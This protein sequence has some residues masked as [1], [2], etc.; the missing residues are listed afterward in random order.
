[1]N[2]KAERGNN[3]STNEKTFGAGEVIIKEGDSGNT[4]FQL[5]EGNVGVYQ[6]YGQ[7]DEVVVAT[8]GP[9]QYFGEMAVIENYPRSSTVVAE[10]EVKVI[11]IAAEE[12]NDYISQ[13]PDKI[14]TI[15]K[16][17]GS[18]IKTMTDDYNDAKAMLDDIRKVNSSKNYDSFFNNMMQKSIFLSAKNFRMEQPSAESL[19]EAAEEVSKQKT[20]DVITYKYGTIIFKQGEA[21][22]CM[23][24]VHSGSVNLYS[25]YGAVNELKLAEVTP[26]ACFG[27][28]GMISGEARSAT[29]VTEEND[30]SVE[31]IYP[32]DL[33]KLFKES[34]AKI[35]MILK[36]L[37]YRLRRITYDYFKACQEIYVATG[38]DRDE[39]DD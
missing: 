4:F 7:K 35:D 23:Y 8:L 1:M 24:I 19:R 2:L 28:M 26:V 17:L 5:L 29:A 12:L 27:E 32:E 33:E 3:M 6:N 38:K 10:G 25:N 37:S 18:R 11:E 36:N 31:V 16:L 14:L 13:Y 15:M 22:K 30:T 20:E 9:G 34:P 21:S 39:D